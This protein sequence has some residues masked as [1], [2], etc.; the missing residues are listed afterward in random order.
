M[1]R[2][3]AL[4]A[5][6]GLALGATLPTETTAARPAPA[7]EWQGYLLVYGDTTGSTECGKVVIVPRADGS[8]LVWPDPTS[9]EGWLAD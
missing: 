9:A 8:Y 3:D 6:A 1:N 4:K 5:G 2:R 7:P